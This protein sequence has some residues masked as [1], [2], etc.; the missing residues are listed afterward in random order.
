V[1]LS[2][3]SMFVRTEN[4]EIQ[5]LISF[6]KDGNQ[7]LN[8]AIFRPYGPKIVKFSCKFPSVRMENSEYMRI[9]FRPHGRK[10]A[11]SYT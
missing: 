6:H 9:N 3:E 10:I 4:S 11:N 2:A 7:V 1:A 8:L 5:R